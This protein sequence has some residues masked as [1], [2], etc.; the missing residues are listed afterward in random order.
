MESLG[1]Y[2]QSGRHEADVT[3]EDLALRTRI[4]IENLRS[5]EKGDLEALPSDPYV[6]GFV[7]VVCRE[8]GLSPDD[9]LVRYDILRERLSPPDEMTWDEESKRRERG[10]LERALE[11]PERIITL[12][13][14]AG[15]GLLGAGAV[16]IVALV[17][18]WTIRGV[19]SF[20]GREAS[21][22]NPRAD[23]SGLLVSA[24]ER[25]PADE[26]AVTIAPPPVTSEDPVAE[27][28]VSGSKLE[29]PEAVTPE[30][31]PESAEPEVA[32]SEP[33]AE[34]E[35]PEV[36]TSDPEPEIEEPEV[37]T[38]EREPE[39]LDSAPDDL[40]AAAPETSAPTPELAVVED[41][42]PPSSPD[43]ENAP[44]ALSEPV[45][46]EVPASS[47]RASGQRLILRV[48][49]VRP[50]EV[51]VLL[52]GIGV[53]RTRRL[54]AG[55]F[56]IWKADSLFL[57]SATD[58]GAVRITLEGAPVQSLGPDGAAVARAAIRP[59]YR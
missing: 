56:K 24:D 51:G 50:V 54:T 41:V 30:P 49:A 48:E 12:A 57:F 4:R 11:D 27:E 34:T 15:K 39:N 29:E 18:F 38:S 52:D 35:E 55:E 2:L 42:P 59:E 32:K 45:R 1:E 28:P 40:P 8:L 7:K 22:D 14:T 47:R 53:P 10:R 17:L 43:Q 6:R 19:G 23:D 9:G 33:E 16:A 3:L 21:G 58:A 25:S 46:T 31:K 37:A 26:A 36:A 20:I 13:R 44:A 5:L